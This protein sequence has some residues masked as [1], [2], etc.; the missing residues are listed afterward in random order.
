MAAGK[1]SFI[2]RKA[3]ETFLHDRSV[4]WS[5]YGSLVINTYDLTF[6]NTVHIF[7]CA[8]VAAHAAGI[9]FFRFCLG[10]VASGFFR[11]DGQ[12]EHFLPV[13]ILP[14]S[15]HL[16]VPVGCAFDPFGNVG[17]MGS[18]FGSNDPFFYII[19]VRE[20]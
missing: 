13:Q 8:E 14:G 7:H 2:C 4:F 17:G 11:I 5:D 6:Q 18:D 1:V 16:T 15:A 10:T 9:F 3:L 20:S 12:T 19:Y